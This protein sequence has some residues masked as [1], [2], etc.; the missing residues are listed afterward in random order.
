MASILLTSLISGY[1]GGNQAADIC[2]FVTGVKRGESEH[3][4]NATKWSRVRR[5]THT[6]VAVT[7]P[8]RCAAGTETVCVGGVF[9]V[10]VTVAPAF[11]MTSA[12]KARLVSFALPAPASAPCTGTMASL[13]QA[14]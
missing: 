5:W 7:M 6:F 10:R 8:R 2:L 1:S 3:C 9:V 12:S 4:A 13:A 11:A 14:N